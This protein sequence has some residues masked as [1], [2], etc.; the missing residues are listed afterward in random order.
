MSHPLLP[1]SYNGLDMVGDLQF[2]ENIRYVVA[3][4]FLVD[5]QCTCDLSIV[6]AAC[7][8][9]ETS[10]SRSVS[11]GNGCWDWGLSWTKKLISR[12]AIPRLV[13]G[14]KSQKQERKLACGA[15]LHRVDDVSFCF[16]L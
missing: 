12:R 2:I 9:V 3:D 6:H 11:S 16:V 1:R 13:S 10:R 4:G 5:D 8:Q 15:V 14:A 7:Q